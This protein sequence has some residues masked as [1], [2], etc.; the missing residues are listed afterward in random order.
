ML[1][2]EDIA[3]HWRWH[4][5]VE[6]GSLE[7]RNIWSRKSLGEA[8]K[9]L[10]SSIFRGSVGPATALFWSFDFQTSERRNT[11]CFKSP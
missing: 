3:I 1:E 4:W 9:G 11:H 10:E 2:T 6:Q 7:P 5:R 8:G